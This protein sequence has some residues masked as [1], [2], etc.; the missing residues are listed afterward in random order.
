MGVG[1]ALRKERQQG[2]AGFG[3]RRTGISWCSSAFVSVLFLDRSKAQGTVCLLA[4]IAEKGP[5][6]LGKA[7]ECLCISNVISGTC[8]GLLRKAK[9]D[10][11]QFSME[12]AE[13]I[14][15]QAENCARFK[16][17]DFECIWNC[18][19]IG[20]RHGGEPFKSE[21]TSV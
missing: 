14:S 7:R 11:H 19:R 13:A 4:V 17:G 20:S 12:Q 10:K 5:F 16:G 21:G 18:S 1:E 9:S 2:D 15:V 3:L 8:F 6:V